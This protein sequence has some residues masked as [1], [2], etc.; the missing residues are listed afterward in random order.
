MKTAINY[1]KEISLKDLQNLLKIISEQS[2]T[3]LWDDATSHY[4]KKI[5]K[6]IQDECGFLDDFMAVKL[7]KDEASNRL[8]N[9]DIKELCHEASLLNLSV[10]HSKELSDEIF[11]D[12]YELKNH[13]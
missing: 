2:K 4:V 8:M 5:S 11:E 7:I 6:L 1:L 13:A 10:G 9:L 3:G 12:W